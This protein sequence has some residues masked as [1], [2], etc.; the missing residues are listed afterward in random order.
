MLGSSPVGKE[1]YDF[2]QIEILGASE[3]VMGE[4]CNIRYWSNGSTNTVQTSP[5]V[6]WHIGY[7]DGRNSIEIETANSF[8]TGALVN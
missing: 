1:H 4:R 7:Y 8:Y 2:D 6:N 5:V 3:P